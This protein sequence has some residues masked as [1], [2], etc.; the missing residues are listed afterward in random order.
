MI[1]FTTIQT[2]EIL[3]D[4]A[5]LQERALKLDKNNKLLITIL[6]GIGIFAGAL[7]IF[8]VLQKKKNENNRNL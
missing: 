4:S 3:P 6:A 5:V 2:F 1:D 7:T 8:Y